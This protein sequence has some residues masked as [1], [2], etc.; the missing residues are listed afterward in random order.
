MNAPF[1]FDPWW[2]LLPT[3]L[4]TLVVSAR[5][6]GFGIYAAAEY[7]ASGIPGAKFIGLDHGGHLFV[8]RDAEV[9]VYIIKLLVESRM[10]RGFDAAIGQ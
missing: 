1:L 10:Q 3:L 5:D 7:T 6:D 9:R 4:T 8:G 2:M